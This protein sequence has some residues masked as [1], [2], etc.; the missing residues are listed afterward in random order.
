MNKVIFFI[1]LLLTDYSYANTSCT[2]H[3]KQLLRQDR[4]VKKYNLPITK[5]TFENLHPSQ[6]YFGLPKIAYVTRKFNYRKFSE[7]KE[8]F[9]D[10]PVYVV[11]SPKGKL[12]IVDAHHH[13]LGA[14]LNFRTLKR[15]FTKDLSELKLEIIEL[16]DFTGRTEVDF[17]QFLKDQKYMYLRK[18]EEVRDLP[19]HVNDLTSD[20]E[21]GIAYLLIKGK[22]ITKDKTPFVEFY[23]ADILKKYIKPPLTNIW[24]KDELLKYSSFVQENRDLFTDILGIKIKNVSKN[25]FSNKIDKYLESLAWYLSQAIK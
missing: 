14:F 13:S 16:D 17:I 6:K 22:V 8:L 23:I 1:F 10:K 24:S 12:W 5:K 11:K 7:I 4:V 18:G 9:E 20:Y 21:R 3:I 15:R 19:R 25:K 2:S